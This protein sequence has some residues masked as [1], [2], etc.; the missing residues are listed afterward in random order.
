MHLPSRACIENDATVGWFRAEYFLYGR[1]LGFPKTPPLIP[2]PPYRCR[3]NLNDARQ[4]LT[5]LNLCLAAGVGINAEVA[6]GCEIP[7][8]RQLR[9]AYVDRSLFCDASLREAEVDVVHYLL[10]ADG[11]WNRSGYAHYKPSPVN[12]SA[13]WRQRRKRM[14]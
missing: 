10:Q 14:R 13:K 2:E 4:M 6:K 12:T 7:D 5:T 11:G 9:E 3:Y 8:L 1:P